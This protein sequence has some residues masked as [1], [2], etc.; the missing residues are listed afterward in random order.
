RMI[1][2]IDR[3]IGRIRRELDRL[4]LADDT[5][6]MLMGDNGYFLGERGF[7]GKW[8][9]YDLSLRVPWLV[10]DPRMPQARRGREPEPMVLNVDVCPT[11]LEMAGVPVPEAVQGR[12]VVPLLRGETPGD[13]RTG[14]FCEHLFDHGKIPKYEGVRTTRWKYARYFEQD[15]VHEE[16]HDL[17]EDPKET[18]N[19]ADDPKY[20]D[21]LERLRQRCD[22]LRDAYGG[23]YKPRPRP[24]RR[25]P[26][27]EEGGAGFQKGVKGKAAVFDGHHFL[28]A[29]TVPAL[30]K[31]EA[32][33][34]SFWVNLAATGAVP[35]VV[36]GNRRPVDGSDPLQFMKVTRETVQCFNGRAHSL[37]LT[38]GIEPGEWVHVAVVKDGT[39]LTCY[40]DGKKVASGAMDFGLPA[41]PFYLGGDPQAGALASCLLD[42]VALYGRALSAAEVQAL[43]R[44][45]AAPAGRLDHWPLDGPAE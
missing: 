4:G 18:T 12:S 37:K 30:G 15:P 27:A 20:R 6:I 9:H 14:F 42:E 17:E 3:V 32:F 23:P 22:E 38:H 40:A 1:S 13:W 36:V 25:R 28:P 8:N 29:G 39:T 2:G 16:L 43:G 24:R 19:L 11:M 10:Y 5:V 31:D 41:L 21:V 33:S 45:E 26:R 44:L 7:A 35:G 34:W